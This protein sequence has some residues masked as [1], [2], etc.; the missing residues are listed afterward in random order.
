MIEV[1]DLLN[2]FG[3]NF[4]GGKIA[5][6]IEGKKELF[7]K[8]ESLLDEIDPDPDQVRKRNRIAGR[9]GLAW[10]GKFSEGLA[11]GIKKGARGDVYL[12]HPLTL[13]KKPGECVSN[14]FKHTIY[15]AEPSIDG[16]FWV[17][18][19]LNGSLYWSPATE[20]G[21]DTDKIFKELFYSDQGVYKARDKNNDFCMVK[22]SGE[23]LSIKGVTSFWKVIPFGEGLAWVQIF[24]NGI[25]H[26]IDKEGTILEEL[27]EGQVPRPFKDDKCIIA[28]S[29]SSYQIR[30][31]DGRSM[32]LELP[33]NE[34]IMLS[35]AFSGD[36]IIVGYNGKQFKYRRLANEKLVPLNEA[37]PAYEKAWPFRDGI[38]LVKGR[39]RE[40]VNCYWYINAK[41]DPAFGSMYGCGYE[42]AEEFSQGAAA[43]QHD[44]KEVSP[45]NTSGGW[46][47]IGQDG[48]PLFKWGNITKHFYRADSFKDGMALVQ[49]QQS[50]APYYIDKSGRRI[51]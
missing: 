42:E 44:N 4:K 19:S 17:Y 24:S 13:V 47:Y 34:I 50:S 8:I 10:L 2:N 35:E 25:Y 41:G 16:I 20:D 18:Y 3:N 29:N 12:G 36:I 38:A 27:P 45:D 30:F 33:E 39:F 43:V 6:A 11:W 51:F 28:R 32:G 5:E 40:N 26:L 21:I 46:S 48:K 9:L 15:K 22:H 14:E 49:D 7:T 37:D 31:K 23:K 1:I